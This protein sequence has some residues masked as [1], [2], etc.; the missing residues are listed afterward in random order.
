MASITGICN[1]ALGRI[2]SKRINNYETDT[3]AEAIHCRIHYQQT[4]ESLLRS[5]VWQF[6]RKR[7]S[8]TADI[9]TPGFE[10][11]YQFSLPS[12]FLRLVEVYQLDGYSGLY[13]LEG[14]KILS[15]DDTLNIKYIRNVADPNEF[16]PLFTEIAVLKLALNLLIPLGGLNTAALREVMM[17]ELKISTS[18]ARMVMFDENNTT[19]QSDWLLAR[20]FNHFGDDPANL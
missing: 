11:G 4:I 18:R 7:A 15:D 16:D 13:T 3:S 20:N 19:G 5:G 17:N 9:S 6:A 12:D 8:L 14:N 10:W 1:Q 2:G